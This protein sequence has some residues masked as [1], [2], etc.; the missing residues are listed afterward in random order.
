MPNLPEAKARYREAASELD[1]Q[2]MYEGDST[3]TGGQVYVRFA[4][5]AEYYIY[6][7]EEHIAIQKN[8]QYAPRHRR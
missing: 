8:A 5:A 1:R 6:A 7:L 4:R 3:R 2:R